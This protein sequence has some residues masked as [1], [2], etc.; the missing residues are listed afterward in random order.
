MR[1]KCLGFAQQTPA[2]TQLMPCLM[3]LSIF[4]MSEQQQACYR[5]FCLEIWEFTNLV[6]LYHKAFC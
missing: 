5:V 4:K 6:S 2:V 1:R 3:M